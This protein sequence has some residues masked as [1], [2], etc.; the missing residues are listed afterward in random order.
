[1]Y[2][3]IYAIYFSVFLYCLMLFFL[4]CWT[5]FCWKAR[6]FPPR[7]TQKQPNKFE[8]LT[9]FWIK[10]YKVFS[11]TIS[12]WNCADRMPPKWFIK[13]WIRFSMDS[14]GQ[15]PVKAASWSTHPVSDLCRR[16]FGSRFTS[17]V[18]GYEKWIASLMLY[19]KGIW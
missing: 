3:K 17:I 6:A 16:D 14:R 13:H 5:K 7:I 4:E 19:M 10:Y 9:F 11:N 15:V 18:T 1:M 2:I 12:V 8:L